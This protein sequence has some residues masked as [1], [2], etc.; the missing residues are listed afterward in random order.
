[1]NYDSKQ[2]MFNSLVEFYGVF[3]YPVNTY[4]NISGNYI[5][6]AIIKRDDI[7]ECIVM[8]V[9]LIDFKKIIVRTA[10]KSYF[11]EFFC[12]IFNSCFNNRFDVIFF[13]NSI[14]NIFCVESYSTQVF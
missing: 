10:N 6:F 4:K 5:V 14:R 3:F 1:M 8:E 9:L 12:F 13:L 2:F 11:S 7:R